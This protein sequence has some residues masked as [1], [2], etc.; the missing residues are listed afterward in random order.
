MP[1]CARPASD[2]EI[3][4]FGFNLN[5]RGR[6]CDVSAV[7]SFL[8][9][10]V[11]LFLSLCVIMRIFQLSSADEDILGPRLLSVLGRLRLVIMDF[12]SSLMSQMHLA[13]GVRMEVQMSRVL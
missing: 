4:R 1:K 7:I 11:C 13:G 9:K 10:F 5:L 2:S 3:Q 6:G 12:G 8:F